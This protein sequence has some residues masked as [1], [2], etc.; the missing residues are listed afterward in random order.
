MR[1]KHKFIAVIFFSILTKA[2]A[3]KR[4]SHELAKDSSIVSRPVIWDARVK[5]K[6]NE[7][8]NSRFKYKEEIIRSHN[9][10][11]KIEDKN[12]NSTATFSVTWEGLESSG[13]DNPMTG[14]AR[15]FRSDNRVKLEPNNQSELLKSWIAVRQSFE[16]PGIGKIRIKIGFNDEV[17][18]KSAQYRDMV[19]FYEKLGFKNLK[20][21]EWEVDRRSLINPEDL[22]DG[23]EKD[24]G[25]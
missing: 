23:A 4:C 21:N 14:I 15:I 1:T 12:N 5:A 2:Y 24:L 3:A 17:S 11:V 18:K 25:E 10:T 19:A 6:P 7:L 8:E 16:D 20:E 9:K 13:K 22:Y